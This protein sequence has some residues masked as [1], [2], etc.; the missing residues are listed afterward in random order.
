VIGLGIVRIIGDEARVLHAGEQPGQR[1]RARDSGAAVDA[2]EA[3]TT[4]RSGIHVASFRS[5]ASAHTAS[6]PNAT[7]ASDRARS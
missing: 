1:V 6:R 5:P 3:R 4:T 2:A 7:F